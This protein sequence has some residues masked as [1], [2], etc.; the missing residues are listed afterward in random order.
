MSAINDRVVQ[1]QD[2]RTR[3][4]FDHH[5]EAS[6]EDFLSACVLY[7]PPEDQLLEFASYGDPEPTVF[8]GGRLPTKAN[9]E[10]LPEMVDPPIRSLADLMGAKDWYWHRVL[11][12]IGAKYLEPWGVDVQALLETVMW[13]VPGLYEEHLETYR[14]YSRRYY[15]EV[16]EHTTRED[17][18]KAFHMIRSIEPPKRNKP[19]RDRLTAVQCAILH[20][21][22]NARD[23][24]DRRRWRWTFEK[25]ADKFGLQGARAAK[26]YVK[27]GKQILAG[28]DNEDR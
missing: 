8:S 15:I 22:H 6:W 5:L 19:P 10:G 17:V 26:D 16:A 27:L 2:S 28:G 18:E 13:E 14:R 23:P 3:G 4:P 20:G 12:H 11:D 24:E 25:L 7:D 9:L 21:D 1:S